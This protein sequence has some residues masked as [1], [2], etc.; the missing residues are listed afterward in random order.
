M[1]KAIFIEERK[2]D[3]GSKFGKNENCEKKFPTEKSSDEEI[4][5]DFYEESRKDVY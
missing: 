3:S 4:D 5:M 2:G 1:S